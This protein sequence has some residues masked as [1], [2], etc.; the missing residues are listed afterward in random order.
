[1]FPTLPKFPDMKKEEMIGSKKQFSGVFKL[2]RTDNL[3]NFLEQTKNDVL[4]DIKDDIDGSTI[5]KFGRIQPKRI[6]YLQ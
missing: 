1:M 2:Y 4:R 5:E 6:V 3:F